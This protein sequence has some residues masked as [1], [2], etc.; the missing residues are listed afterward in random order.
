MKLY[1][2]DMPEEA[3]VA[4][5]A[6]EEVYGIKSNLEKIE[7]DGVFT[8]LPEFDGFQ[9]SSQQISQHL[10]LGKGKSVLVLTPRDIYYNN[11]S[12]LDDWIFGYSNIFGLNVVSSARMK[13]FDSSPSRELVVPK[14]VFLGRLLQ[15]VVH[16]IGHDV[17]HGKHFKKTYWVNT[18]KGYK[19]PLGSHCSDNRCVMYEVVDINAPPRE[20]GHMKLGNEISRM[21]LQRLQVFSPDYWFL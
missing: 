7:L 3:E 15:V 4:A 17:V 11:K 21:V 8:P 9:S 2:E 18:K 12:K 1:H 6:L 5:A 16:E 20:E 14:N 13:G 19:L 10:D